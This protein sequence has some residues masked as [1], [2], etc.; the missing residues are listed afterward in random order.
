MA[1]VIDTQRK[2]DEDSVG[3]ISIVVEITWTGCKGVVS[4]AITDKDEELT[5]SREHSFS[6]VARGRGNY[7]KAPMR[8]FYC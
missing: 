2:E 4:A 7:L 5:E 8:V 1:L 6:T 3:W